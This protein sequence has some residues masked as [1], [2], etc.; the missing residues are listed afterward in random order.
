MLIM[1]QI[2][3]LSATQAL[4]MSGTFLFVL[5]G[6]II[7]SQLAPA[8]GLATLPVSLM[9]VGL[10]ASVLPAGML[11]RRRGRRT[12]FVLGALLAGFGCAIAGLGIHAANFWIFC[13]GALLLGANNAMVMQYRF[14][15]VEYVTPA[16]ASKAIG[17]VMSGALAA[18]WL[19]PE[20][21]VRSADLVAGAHYAG[22][23]F[24]GTGLNLLAAILLALTPVAAGTADKDTRAPRPLLEIAAQADFRVAVLAALV[25]YAVMSF[26]MT[27]TPI[28]MHIIDLHDEVATKR[29]IQGHLL[30]MYLP[31]LA[32]GWIIARFGIRPIIAAGTLLMAS[33]VAIAAFA[34]HEV[35]HYGWALVLLGVGWNL[36]FIAGTTLLTKTYRP[37]ERVQVQTLNDFMVFGSQAVASLMAGVALTTIGW[38]RLNL[39]T[40][41]LLAAVLLSLALAARRR[42]AQQ[43]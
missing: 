26:I 33:C 17:I 9:I 38:Q 39:A 30:A 18:A 20:I 28:S 25:S 6:G 12:A 27:A 36:L 32:S 21:A 43:T 14:A 41:P 13:A 35:L 16:R 15:A 5:L 40:L 8:P 7:G 42:Q 31:S 19:G 4:C 1:Q 3:M 11:I 22:S 10:A 37:Q 29:V 24:T 23:F 2:W 34:G